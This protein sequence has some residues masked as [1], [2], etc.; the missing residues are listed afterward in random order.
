MAFHLQ[1]NATSLECVTHDVAVTEFRKAE[2]SVSLLVEK[3][4]EAQLLVSRYIGLN[5]NLP[6]IH[7]GQLVL[8]LKSLGDG[9]GAKLFLL[10]KFFINVICPSVNIENLETGPRKALLVSYF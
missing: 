9:G 5:M 1:L 7:Q 3:N 6:I 8:G 2:E 10:F 4:A